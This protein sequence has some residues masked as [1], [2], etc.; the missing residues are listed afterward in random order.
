MRLPRASRT[1]TRLPIT[2]SAPPQVKADALGREVQAVDNEFAG[3]L[4]VGGPHGCAWGKNR[5]WEGR[6]RAASLRGCWKWARLG[7]LEWAG[8]GRAPL[9]GS[10]TG[11]WALLASHATAAA[12]CCSLHAYDRRP[13]PHPGPAAQ[14]DACRGLQLRCHTAREGH[15]FRKFGWGNKKSLADDPAAAG[16]DVRAELLAYY[17]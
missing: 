14:S 10:G 13:R 6:Q 4:Q 12:C 9:L 2:A 3:V 5:G 7:L 1:L 17:K 11:A 16:L 15:L 8:W